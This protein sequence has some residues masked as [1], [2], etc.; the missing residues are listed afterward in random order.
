MMSESFSARES[1]FMRISSF[2]VSDLFSNSLK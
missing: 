2:E 1:F